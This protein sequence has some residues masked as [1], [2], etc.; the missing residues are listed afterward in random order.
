MKRIAIAVVEYLL[1]FLALAVF[2]AIAL[3]PTEAP[4]VERWLLAFKV[5]ACLAT[6]ELAAL[7]Y[8]SVPANRLIIG[9]NLWLLAGGIAAFTKQWWWLRGYERLGEASLF[10]IILLVGAVTTAFSRAGFVG[11]PGPRRKVV[12]L[13]AALLVG[14][15]AALVASIYYRG[16]AKF[17]AVL[18]IIALSWFNRL[19]KRGVAS[20]A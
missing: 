5:G 4:T 1:G 20:G 7:V 9:A 14:V 6:L 19:L 12:L 11:A 8:R 3:T 16:N 13:S 10:L 2:A 18:P 15:V 17:A